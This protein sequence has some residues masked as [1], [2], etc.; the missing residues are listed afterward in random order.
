[1]DQN[2]LIGDVPAE[3]IRRVLFSKAADKSHGPD[4]YVSE[5]FKAAMSI[6]GFSLNG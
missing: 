6:I 1:M 5:F 4:G 2:L 3:E